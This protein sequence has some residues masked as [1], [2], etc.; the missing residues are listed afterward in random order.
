MVY[1]R[2]FVNRNEMSAS[3][4]KKKTAPNWEKV[5]CYW[6]DTPIVSRN[7]KRHTKVLHPKKYPKSTRILSVGQS[8][9]FPG[10]AKAIVNDIQ[11]SNLDTNI[12]ESDLAELEDTFDNVTLNS[13]ENLSTETHQKDLCSSD[14]RENKSENLK[15]IDKD[16]TDSENILKSTD[17]G[18]LDEISKDIKEV[19]SVMSE[20]KNNFTG[21][22]ASFIGK[23][24]VV[25][26]KKRFEKPRS[27]LLESLEIN[28]A[29]DSFHKC[30][31]PQQL[32]K[33]L[34]QRGFIYL[35]EVEEIKCVL[36]TQSNTYANYP[37]VRQTG[38]KKAGVFKFKMPSNML[39]EEEDPKKQFRDFV[40]IKK[41]F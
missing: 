22:M 18:A 27:V 30:K 36:C 33:I 24:L 4:P 19:F 12:L 3:T 31:N 35:E 34:P 17:G 26:E 10:R 14:T 5:K 23:Q 29:Q 25:S 21:M 1:F 16:C 15:S 2:Y 32:L 38:Y 37:N 11:D 9:L 6:C 20:L 40:N 8:R 7:L 13:N 41:N 39:D 28:P